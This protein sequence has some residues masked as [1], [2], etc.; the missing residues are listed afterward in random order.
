M[1]AGDARLSAVE[2]LDVYATM[3][4]VRIHDVLRDEYARTAAVLGGEAFHD[5]VTD[6]LQACPPAHPSLREAGARLPAFL[7]AHALAADRPWLAELARLERA[8]LE[9]FDGPDAA[10]LSIAALRDVRAR[11]IRRAPPAPDPGAPVARATAS[12][13]R[14]PGAPTIPARR[15]PRARARDADRLAPRRRRLSPRRPTRTR[16]AGCR[17]W[18]TARASR[19]RACARRSARRCRT[20]SP[21]RARSSWSRAGRARDCCVRAA[22]LTG[23][24]APAELPPRPLGVQN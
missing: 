5:L 8:R 13:S 17:G 23:R 16:R 4:F 18:R 22:L 2:R 21:P 14:R 6:Y 9:V 12:R 24:R 3:Y 7:A 10:P 1:V 11:T 20:R 19:S 15:S